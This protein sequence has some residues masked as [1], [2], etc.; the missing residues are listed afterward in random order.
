[1]TAAVADIEKRLTATLNT[2]V[3]VK[4]GAHQGRIVIEYYGN[5]DLRRILEKLGMQ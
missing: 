3:Q 4:H 1:V 5:E 2:K